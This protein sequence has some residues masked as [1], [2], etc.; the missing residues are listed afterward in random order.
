MFYSGA[1]LSEIIKMLRELDEKKLVYLND[2]CRYGLFWERGRK[3]HDLIYVLAEF[4]DKV[5]Q[6]KGRVGKHINMRESGDEVVSQALLPSPRIVILPRI[7]YYERSPLACYPRYCN[8][9]VC[10]LL[11]FNYF[12]N[13]SL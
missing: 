3:H 2:F 10:C 12:V 9:K 6:V 4:V 5:K 11:S 1:H 7:C 13:E 8:G